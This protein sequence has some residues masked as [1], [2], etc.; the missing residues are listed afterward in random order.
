[1]MEGELSSKEALGM[2]PARLDLTIPKLSISTELDL[3]TTL[4]QHNIVSI[5][6]PGFHLGPIYGENDIRST[7]G[8]AKHK[9]KFDVDE[10]GI[11]AAAVTAL[12]MMSRTYA[13]RVK[14]DRPFYF[15]LILKT[16][17]PFAL[18]NGAEIFSGRVVDP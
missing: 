11:D 10:K 5:F 13:T 6:V 2:R 18:K 17:N 15:R 16:K 9:V 14:I 3:R 1:M 8:E 4:K 12:S 7:L